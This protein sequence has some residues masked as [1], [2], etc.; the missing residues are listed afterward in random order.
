MNINIIIVKYGYTKHQ[1]SK[2]RTDKDNK[3][4]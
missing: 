2:P 4:V 3:A 1:I